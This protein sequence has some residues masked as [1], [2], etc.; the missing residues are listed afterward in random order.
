MS[1]TIHYHIA[2]IDRLREIAANREP[3]RK[4]NGRRIRR[5]TPPRVAKSVRH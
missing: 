3:K 2:M 4:P 5:K 1:A